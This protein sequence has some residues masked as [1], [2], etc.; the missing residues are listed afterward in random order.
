[1]R[2]KWILAVAALG[3][4]VLAGAPA[5]G[6][7][8][9]QIRAKCSAAWSGSKTTAAFRS[10]RT[11][12]TA[13]AKAAISDATDAGNPTSTAANR[14]RAQR[15]CNIKFPKPRN[16]A[17]KRKKY[18]ACVSA[19]TNAQR[20]YALRALRATLKGSNEV[21]GAGGATGTASVRV[22]VGAK[23]VCVTLTFTNFG[24]AG[25]LA[26][27]IHK[28]AA[29]VDGGVVLTIYTPQALSDLDHHTPARLCVNGGASTAVLRDIRAH[30]GNYYVNIH[31][32]Q[33]PDGAARGQLHR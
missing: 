16:T 29:G 15:A 25:A 31:N 12:C 22:N 23:R 6:A 8:T 32:T 21:G 27:H 14:V 10:F 30:P 17:A 5:Q 28:G 9:S 4:V 24:A 3:C 7:T 20:A 33:F 1:M 11:R 2:G 13:A 26:A 18:N 19:T